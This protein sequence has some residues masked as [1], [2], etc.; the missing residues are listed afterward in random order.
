MNDLIQRILSEVRKFWFIPVM[1]LIGIVFMV[2]QN[3]SP[4]AVPVSAM[5]PDDQ[6]IFDTEERIEEMLKNIDG[7]GE[8]KVAITLASGSKKE[9]VREAGNVLVITDNQGNQ[10]AVIAKEVAPEIAGV[11]VLCSGAKNIEVQKDIIHSVS[12]LL[13][14]G[15][16]KVCVILLG[17]E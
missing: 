17:E 6:Y 13:G 4:D 10:S 8:C 12:I 5:M 14:I 15:S 7:A 9:Y 3:K 11:T 1:M 2:Y 16:N